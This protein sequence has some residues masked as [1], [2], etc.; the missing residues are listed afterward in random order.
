MGKLYEMQK[1]TAKVME[2]VAGENGLLVD[3]LRVVK[4]YTQDMCNSLNRR[5]E[6]LGSETTRNVRDL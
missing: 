3:E 4:N 6:T 5:M 1:K 2:R